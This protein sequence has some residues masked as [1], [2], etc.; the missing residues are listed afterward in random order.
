MQARIDNINKAQG[1]YKGVYYLI[2]WKY[3]TIEIKTF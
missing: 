2:H 1:P 3:E